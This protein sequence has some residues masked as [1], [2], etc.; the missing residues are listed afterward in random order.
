MYTLPCILTSAVNNTLCYVMLSKQY[1]N[2]IYL[3]IGS[4]VNCIQP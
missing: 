1:S 3:K 2:P 4:T